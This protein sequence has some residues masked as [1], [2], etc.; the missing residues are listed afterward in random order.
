MEFRIE[1]AL[2]A[3]LIL[4]Y[5]SPGFLGA[6]CVVPGIEH[7]DRLIERSEF[8][9]HGLALGVVVFPV[10]IA[11]HLHVTVCGIV[12]VPGE[13]LGHRLFLDG[14]EGSQ[15]VLGKIGIDSLV[16][17]LP[18]THES[19]SVIVFHLCRSDYGLHQNCYGQ[20]ESFHSD[21]M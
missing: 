5:I 11:V 6:P 4:F 20:Q 9:V 2:E 19:V 16:I 8:F 10:Y 14:F 15:L 12:P 21:S 3:A 7:H 17:G 18:E 13:T 1:S